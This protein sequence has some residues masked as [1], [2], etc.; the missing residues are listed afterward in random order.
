MPK[1]MKLSQKNLIAYQT[2]IKMNPIPF[3]KPHCM[4][5]SKKTI[6]KKEKEKKKMTDYRKQISIIISYCK[7]AVP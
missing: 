6:V 5:I 4:N 3:E 7:H 2:Y 1:C